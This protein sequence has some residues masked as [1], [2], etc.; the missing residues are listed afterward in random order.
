MTQLD[1]GRVKESQWF[2]KNVWR[3]IKLALPKA[4][5]LIV[6]KPPIKPIPYLT[7]DD[8]INIKG[9][10]DDLVELFNTVR[11]AVVPTFHGTGLINRIL[12]ALTANVPVISTPQAIR[13]F[14]S[15]EVGKHILAAQTP[16]DFTNEIVHLFSDRNY[17]IQIG[18]EGRNYAK[19]FPTWEESISNIELALLSL[20]SKNSC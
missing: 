7:Y 4:K 17:R 14:Q 20:N 5:L 12:D 8:S 15:I 18:N 16:K 2:I 10:A 11:I 6:G 3:K 19:N 13:T 1:G 9:F